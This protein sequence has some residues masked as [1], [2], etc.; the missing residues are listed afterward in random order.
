MFQQPHTSCIPV[1]VTAVL[2]NAEEC[3][4]LQCQDR[5][6]DSSLPHWTQ[7][8]SQNLR[9]K[10][11]SYPGA[12]WGHSLFSSKNNSCKTNTS[13]KM[14]EVGHIRQRFG[15]SVWRFPI[16][17]KHCSTL[18]FLLFSFPFL[19]FTLLSSLSPPSLLSSPSIAISLWKGNSVKEKHLKQHLCSAL[20]A[21]R[22]NA[23]M[24]HD[25][26]QRLM[27]TRKHQ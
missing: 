22:I 17:S 1:C 13:L 18:F 23:K 19:L 7:S 10:S 20:A 12:T 8:I 4:S 3:H 11:G 25:C 9:L 6:W 21:G 5:P 24:A 27:L 2:S 14:T 16:S 15:K 26:R